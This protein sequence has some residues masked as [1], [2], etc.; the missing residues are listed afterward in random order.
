MYKIVHFRLKFHDE[1][2]EFRLG[3]F[4]FA[5]VLV[6]MSKA[7]PVQASLRPRKIH[8]Y[9]LYIDIDTYT[10]MYMYMYMYMC[11]CNYVYVYVYVGVYNYIY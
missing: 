3:F 9:I 7:K 1:T 10:Y 8:M 4:G 2:Y 5:K 11:I 6:E